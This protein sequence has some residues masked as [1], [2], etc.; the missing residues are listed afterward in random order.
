MLVLAA[1]TGG[2]PAAPD[3]AA[4][5][6]AAE[7]ERILAGSPSDLER[8]ALADGRISDAEMNEALNAFKTCLEALPHGFSVDLRADGGFEV[9]GFE[10]FDAS[11]RTDEE[12]TSARQALVS[13]CEVGTTAALGPLHAQMR[14]NPEGRTPVQLIRECF[15]RH[16]V[17]DGA[18]LSDDAFAELVEDPQWVP[19]TPWARS[20]VINSESDVLLDDPGV[21]IEQDAG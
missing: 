13:E 17:P 4:P 15:A 10:A 7:I 2:D 11:F 16:D 20:C 18:E 6:F 8:R 14:D 3:D 12:A 21:E 9:S 19:S 5:L 1:C